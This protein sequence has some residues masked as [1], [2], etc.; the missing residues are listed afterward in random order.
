[1]ITEQQAHALDA[2]LNN[3]RCGETIQASEFYAV[4]A[5]PYLALREAHNIDILASRLM[6]CD[7]E[8]VRN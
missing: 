5:F 6:D 2:A 8:Y 4:M 1:M 3:R 7:Q